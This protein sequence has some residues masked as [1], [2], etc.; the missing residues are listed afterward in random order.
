MLLF[1][2]PS[3]LIFMNNQMIFALVSLLP[4]VMACLVANETDTSG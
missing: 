2:V 3:V 4:V 1:G